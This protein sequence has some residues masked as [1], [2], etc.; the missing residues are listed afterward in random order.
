LIFYEA[1]A[2]AEA[3]FSFLVGAGFQKPH[4]RS[5]G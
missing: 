2:A 4:R 1:E 3:A 5:I